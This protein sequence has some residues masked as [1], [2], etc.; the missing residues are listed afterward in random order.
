MIRW[1]D[2]RKRPS[3]PLIPRKNFGRPKYELTDFPGM[4]WDVPIRQIMQETGISEHCAVRLRAEAGQSVKPLRKGRRAFRYTDFDVDWSDK[5][6]TKKLEKLTGLSRTLVYR[7]RKQW[8][9]S[10]G[11]VKNPGKS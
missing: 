2:A 8:R 7:M 11:E 3:E 1:G 5:T 10:L 9:E 4:N 6:S